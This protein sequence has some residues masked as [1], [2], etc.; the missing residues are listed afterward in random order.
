MLVSAGEAHARPPDNVE[1][2][3]QKL[4]ESERRL[5]R[6]IDWIFMPILTITLGL[7]VGELFSEM[8]AFAEQV[9]L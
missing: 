3:L 1:E 5:V 4:R 7:Q 2:Q 9:V 8:L 6:K